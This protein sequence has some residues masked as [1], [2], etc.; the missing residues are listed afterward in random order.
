MDA[1]YHKLR[2]E[3]LLSVCS[4]MAEQADDEVST[5]GYTSK[6][7]AIKD[8]INI[9]LAWAQIHATLATVIEPVSFDDIV[10]KY[11]NDS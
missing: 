10:D 2:A 11:G 7:R 9:G 6:Y 8:N 1:R 4:S 5:Q 3:Y